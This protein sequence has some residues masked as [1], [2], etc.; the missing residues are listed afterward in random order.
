VLDEEQA[1]RATAT[2]DKQPERNIG[3]EKPRSFAVRRRYL[4]FTGSPEF[5]RGEEPVARKLTQHQRKSWCRYSGSLRVLTVKCQKKNGKNVAL[6]RPR[7]IR[8]AF[9]LGVD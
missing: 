9:H 4:L 5:A 3:V 8:I 2:Q 7:P 6:L 1:N